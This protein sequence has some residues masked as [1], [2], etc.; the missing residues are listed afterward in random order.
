M[1]RSIKQWSLVMVILAAS[2]G[3]YRA[4]GTPFEST[5]VGEWIAGDLHVHTIWGHDTCI[6]PLT[7]WDE[8]STDHSLASATPCGDE[9]YTWGYTPE[10]R[11]IES[12]M[13][14]LD[15]LA[16]TDHNNV[17]SQTDPG[18]T[19]YRGSLILVP[20]YENS[21]RGHVQMLG[22]T[23]CY[24]NIGPTG[25][26]IGCNKLVTDQSA[27]GVQSVANAL[28][29]GGGAFQINHPSDR[30]WQSF[31]DPAW[32][33]TGS[34]AFVPDTIEVWNIGA[35]FWQPPMPASNDNDFSLDYW[36]GY[37]RAGHRV[38]ATGGSDSHWRLTGSNQGVGEPTTWV[39]VTERSAQ[40][41]L[42]GIKSGRT[43]ISHEPPNRGGARAFLEADGDGD[44]VFESMVG[45]AVPGTS[46]FRIRTVGAVPGSVIRVVHGNGSFEET[47]S[48]TGFD[49]D[50][51]RLGPT[52]K[53]VRVE[54]RLPDVQEERVENCAAILHE[55][56]EHTGQTPPTGTYCVNRLAIQSLTSPIYIN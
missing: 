15:Y 23:S 31:Y 1:S 55:I 35:W 18:V 42:D 45:D 25:Q 40:G 48:G 28:R 32:R 7:R 41:V 14:G 34:F 10:E 43:F 30:S 29:A 49:F 44:G 22:A 19:G 20:A 16:I 12:E 27:A 46:R 56:R 52:P 21:L 33:E 3:T 38:G 13:R 24:D 8:T 26:K 51:P 36:D 39:W 4:L 37:L 50:S 47:L 54:V 17:L 2:F 11:I 6:T 5:T 9:P 53:F